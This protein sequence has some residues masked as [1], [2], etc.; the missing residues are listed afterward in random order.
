MAAGQVTLDL[1]SL[2]KKIRFLSDQRNSEFI[3]DD[4]IKLFLQSAFNDIYYDICEVDKNWFLKKVEPKDETHLAPI[5]GPENI[6]S[7]DADLTDINISTNEIFQ[8]SDSYLE[9]VDNGTKLI[10][11]SDY[12]KLRL[13]LYDSDSNFPQN[14]EPIQIT[15]MYK[16]QDVNLKYYD[17]VNEKS[18]L[19]Y[20]HFKDHL[21]LLTKSFSLNKITL[22]YTPVPSDIDD[23]IMFPRGFDEYLVYYVASEI[24]I[25]ENVETKKLQQRALMWKRKIMDWAMNRDSS[26]PKTIRDVYGKYY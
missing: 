23:N 10:L 17:S 9:M 4:E 21:L 2:I 12:H 14:F 26:F 19:K 15:E 11:P 18:I 3:S 20:V 25:G 6:I 24:G 1:I 16:Y 7:P 8:H 13:L 22:Y 5:L